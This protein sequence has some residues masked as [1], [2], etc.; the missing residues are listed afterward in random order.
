MENDE[1]TIE[2]G[3]EDIDRALAKTEWDTTAEQ[4]VGSVN[5]TVTAFY[6]KKGLEWD[7][8]KKIV[9]LK[10][11]GCLN[12]AEIVGEIVMEAYDGLLKDTNVW[13]MWGLGGDDDVDYNGTYILGLIDAIREV[14]RE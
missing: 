1:K 3:F 5:E 11:I 8:E 13:E 12:T 2:I 10:N 9:S 6:R 4:L 7:A 14:L